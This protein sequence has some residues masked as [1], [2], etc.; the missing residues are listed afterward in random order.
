MRKVIWEPGHLRFLDLSGRNNLHSP[1]GKGLPLMPRRVCWACEFAG[2]LL[3]SLRFPLNT[4]I[5]DS[6]NKIS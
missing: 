2:R 4:Q 1:S 6:R 5:I 3:L